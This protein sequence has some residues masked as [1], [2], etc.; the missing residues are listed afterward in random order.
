MALFE[1]AGRPV[2]MFPDP[3]SLIFFPVRLPET[4]ID[5]TVGMVAIQRKIR[6]LIASGELDRS[7]PE[8]I[9]TCVEAIRVWEEQDICCAGQVLR[10]FI[11]ERK[12]DQSS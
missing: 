4:R 7:D 8:L 9:E 12:L 10:R 2:T 6:R 5:A 3:T 1:G 11:E